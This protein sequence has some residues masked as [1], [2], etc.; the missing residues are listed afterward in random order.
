MAAFAISAATSADVPD[1]LRLIK[2]IAEYERL[3]HEV[4]A[5]EAL[6]TESLF[7]ARPVAETLIARTVGDS[8]AVGFALYFSSYS[9]F[10]GGAGI[11]LEDLFVMPEWRGQ[12]L[13]EALFRRVAQIAVERNAGRMEWSVL[14]WNEPAL[15]FYRKLGAKPMNE[16]TVQRLTG[17][18]LRAVASN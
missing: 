6:L 10:L 3:S 1:I 7:G 5:T 14:D 18:A 4:V 11:Y 16:W 15:K 13:G 12:G 8:S 17:E 9:T 2:G